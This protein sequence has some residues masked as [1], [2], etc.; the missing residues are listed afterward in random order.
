MALWFISWAY[1]L[2]IKNCSFGA[3]CSLGISVNLKTRIICI[4]DIWQ[5][6]ALPLHGALVVF[7]GSIQLEMLKVIIIQAR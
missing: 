3:K 4:S 7:V 6:L 2:A 1:L 5:A